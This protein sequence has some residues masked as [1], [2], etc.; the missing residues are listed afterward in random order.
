MEVS[1]R[2]ELQEPLNLDL[3]A[4]IAKDMKDAGLK[5]S[6]NAGEIQVKISLPY[7]PLA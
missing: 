1:A 7:I 4:N 5:A 2:L 6:C 3:L